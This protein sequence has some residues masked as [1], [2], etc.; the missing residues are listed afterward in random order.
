[1]LWNNNVDFFSAY[2]LWF[3]T[4]NSKSLVGK[5]FFEPIENLELSV[6]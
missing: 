3:D 4:F 1:M 6:F 5:F 2:T